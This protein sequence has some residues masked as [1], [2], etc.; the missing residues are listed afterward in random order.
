MAI[1][2]VYNITIIAF[3]SFDRQL[4][5][6]LA[7]E[8]EK[9]LNLPVDLKERHLDLSLFYNIDRRQYDANLLLQFV[10]EEYGNI[11]GKLVALFNVDLF[12]PILTFIY[13]QAYLNGKTAIASNYRLE[14]K[15]YGLKPD[16]ELEK[17]RLIKEIIHELGH[18]LGL[19]HCYNPTCVMRSSTYVEDIDQ[20]NQSLCK[21]CN[22]K[23]KSSPQD[24]D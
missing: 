21:K 13:G 20:K 17:S 19:V 22:S 3:G 1:D 11:P 18:T 6:L 24:E 7:S 23:L 16:K 9:E 8:V 14:N 5:Q 10:N 4:L 15:Y 12:I 2:N